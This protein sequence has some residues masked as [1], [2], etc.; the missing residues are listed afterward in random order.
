MKRPVI[1]EIWITAI[2]IIY[3]DKNKDINVLKEISEQEKLI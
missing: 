2:P 1:G 3:Y